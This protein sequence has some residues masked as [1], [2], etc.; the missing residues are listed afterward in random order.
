MR[1]MRYQLRDGSGGVGSAR[2]GDGLV[3]EIAFETPTEVTL[4]CER[5]RFAPYGLQGGGPGQCGENRLL[6]SGREEVLPSK[7]RFTAQPGDRLIIASPGGGGW[8][9]AA[10]HATIEQGEAKTAKKDDLNTRAALMPF[11]ASTIDEKGH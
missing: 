7:V 10:G 4:L 3:R 8:G 5:H 1:I 2:G 6:R 11:L 9:E